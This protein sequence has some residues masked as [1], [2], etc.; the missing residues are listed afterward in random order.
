MAETYIDSSSGWAITSKTFLFSI[1]RALPESKL[2][3]Y[4]NL[5]IK[6]TKHK[7]LEFYPAY[8]IISPWPFRMKHFVEGFHDRSETLQ[9]ETIH[10]KTT[11]PIIRIHAIYVATSNHHQSLAARAS[12]PHGWKKK[13]EKKKRR[14]QRPRAESTNKQKWTF[15]GPRLSPSLRPEEAR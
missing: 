13:K 1:S 5:K 8:T 11:K 7:Q 6:W 3:K 12:Q 2:R 10:K 4:R 14:N 15:Q 9:S